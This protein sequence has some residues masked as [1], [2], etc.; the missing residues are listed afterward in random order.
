MF[1]TLLKCCVIIISFSITLIAIILPLRVRF[2]YTK[3]VCSYLDKATSKIR[4]LNN[5]IL[6]TVN[7]N[8]QGRKYD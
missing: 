1:R 6:D 5:F 4:F 8:L 3:K 2:L 7:K